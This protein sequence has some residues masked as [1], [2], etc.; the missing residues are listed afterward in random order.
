MTILA[1]VNASECN[2]VCG[3][4]SGT[5]STCTTCLAPSKY[6]LFKDGKC[7]DTCSAGF[8]FDQVNLR[9]VQ[10]SHACENCHKPGDKGCLRCADGYLME[11]GVCKAWCSKTM[12]VNPIARTCVSSYKERCSSKCLTC[13]L[14]AD[15]CLS[16]DQKSNYPVL[17]RATGKCIPKN[18]SYCGG[19]MGQP[20]SSNRF[21]ID[22]DAMECRTCSELCKSCEDQPERCTQCWNGQDKF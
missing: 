7:V 13:S 1:P 14:A 22:K 2:Q 5:N 16:C 6:P 11:D 19:G 17:D 21:Y 9:C 3:T 20:S 18:Q 8:F 4:C 10:C 15:Y 12:L